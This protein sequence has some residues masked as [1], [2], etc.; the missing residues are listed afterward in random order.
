MKIFAQLLQ[1][2]QYSSF[3]KWLVNLL[4][5]RKIPFNRSHRFKILSINKSSIEIKIPYRKSNLNHINGLHA[6]ALAAVSEYA[7][8]LLL[9]FNL[10][11][12][13]YRLILQSLE[14]QFHFQGKTDGIAIF[15]ATQDWIEKNILIPLQTNDNVLA[16]CETKVFDIHKNLLSTCHTNWQIKKWDKVKTKI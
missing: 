5:L 15:S 7:T 2:A 1:K 3:Y 13:D 4:L 10:N 6:C 8:G 14:I 11:A 16:A 9:M 12:A